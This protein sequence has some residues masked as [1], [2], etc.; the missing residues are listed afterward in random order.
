MGQRISRTDVLVNLRNAALD[1]EDA[2]SYRLR[3]VGDPQGEEAAQHGS[4]KLKL[5]ASRWLSISQTAL[6]QRAIYLQTFQ[7]RDG[8]VTIT[9]DV[10]AKDAAVQ[11][12]DVVTIQTADIVDRTGQASTTRCVVIKREPIQ[13]GST[14][15]YTLQPLPQFGRSLLFSVNTMPDYDDA[16]ALEREQGGFIAANTRPY[17]SD[18]SEAYVFTE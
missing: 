14:Y 18:N 3:I 15:R 7:L 17:F 8:M 12:G 10:S 13:A 6:A 5:I 9:A 1:P 2:S 4:P 16:S 11:L